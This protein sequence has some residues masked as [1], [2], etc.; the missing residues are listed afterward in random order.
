MYFNGW[1]QLEDQPIW[2][3]PLAQITWY[4]HISL[5]SKVKDEADRAYC[6]PFPSTRQRHLHRQRRKRSPKDPVL[7]P[8]RC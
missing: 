4:H 2:Q 8:L 3:V 5:L 1:L 7:R 6:G